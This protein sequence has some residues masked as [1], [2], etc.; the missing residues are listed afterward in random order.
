MIQITNL[1]EERAMAAY[2]AARNDLRNRM[3]CGVYPNC[4]ATLAAYAAFEARLS[5]DLADFAEYHTT[6]MAVVLPA[7]AQLQQAMQAI[8]TIMEGVDAAAIAGTG[9]PLFG[10]PLPEPEEPSESEE[11]QTNE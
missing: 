8:C 5:G 10:I 6:S 11:E 9:A 3:A 2:I 1:Q 7:I 4:K